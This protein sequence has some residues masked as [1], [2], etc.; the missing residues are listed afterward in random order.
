MVEKV[1]GCNH[2]LCRCSTDF[3]YACG[4]HLDKCTCIEEDEEEDEE[5]LAMVERMWLARRQVQ[6]RPRTP[7]IREYEEDIIED[8][9]VAPFELAEDEFTDR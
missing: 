6:R 1:D 4:L 5:D 7:V 9:M 8:T 3:C 2:I